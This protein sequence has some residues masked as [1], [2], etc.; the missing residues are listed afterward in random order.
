ML[1]DHTIVMLHVKQPY[2]SSLTVLVI[3]GLHSRADMPYSVGI[4][5]HAPQHFI[6]CGRDCQGLQKNINVSNL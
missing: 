2:D 1:Y 4:Q 6:A 5:K 3:I